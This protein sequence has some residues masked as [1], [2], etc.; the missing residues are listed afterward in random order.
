MMSMIERWGAPAGVVAGLGLAILATSFAPREAAADE[1]RSWRLLGQGAHFRAELEN[2]NT[3]PAVP[4]RGFSGKASAWLA[5]RKGRL[6][7]HYRIESDMDLNAGF[8]QSET[9]EDDVTQIH[10]HNA[11]PGIAG[12]HVL[13]VYKRPAQDDDDLTLLP[14][15]GLVFGIWDD[16]DL[17]EG[18]APGPAS[19]PFS[20]V[21]DELCLGNI[22]V[23]VHG[24]GDQGAGALRGNLEPTRRGARLCRYLEHR[25]D[26]DD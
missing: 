20:E 15:Q 5:L 23:N 21:L 8:P 14:N 6:V 7:L 19:V 12:P 1:F 9:A 18:L 22:Y 17:S 3:V 10:L 16:L 2:A 13:N 24:T 11:P 26:D 4:D 25:D